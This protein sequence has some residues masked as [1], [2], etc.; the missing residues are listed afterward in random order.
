MCVSPCPLFGLNNSSKSWCVWANFIRPY[1]YLVMPRRQSKCYM[2]LGPL[3]PAANEISPRALWEGGWPRRKPPPLLQPS[4]GRAWPATDRGNLLHLYWVLVRE[5][6]FSLCLNPSHSHA[7]SG[8]PRPTSR[9]SPRTRSCNN[10]RRS[11]SWWSLA[12]GLPSSSLGLSV[13]FHTILRGLL[14]SVGT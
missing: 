2:A 1:P 13:S 3:R 10:V 4:P 9:G 12:F 7:S 6:F 5:T 14:I 11:T 8:F